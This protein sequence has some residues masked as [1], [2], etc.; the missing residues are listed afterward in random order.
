MRVPAGC[1][2][3]PHELPA[4]V[5][6]I[7][8][9]HGS[10]WVLRQ[11][12][13]DT[14]SRR[15]LVE[16]ED[17][18]GAQ[19][20]LAGGAAGLIARGSEGGGHVGELTTFVLL[21]HLLADPQID[22]PVWAAGGIGRHSAAAAIAGGAAGVVLDAQLALVRE[23]ALPKEIATAIGAMDGSETTLIGSHRVYTRPD[24]AA[25]R[26]HWP[27]LIGGEL[28]EGAVAQRLGADGFD[29]QLLAV[30]QDGAFARGLAEEF[31]TAGALVQG[32]RASIAAHLADAAAVQPLRADSAFART[33]GVRYP[34]AQ[35]P[36]TRVSDRAAFAAHVAEHGG[37]PFLALALMEG[38]DVRRLLAETAKLLG[39][40]PWGVGIL[41]FAPAQVREAQLAAIQQFR[42][43]CALIAGGRPSQAAPLEAAGI[44]TFMHV[45]SPGLL[46]RFLHEGARKFVFEGR[47]CGG[48]VGPRA[49]FALWD[50]QVEALLRFGEST[51]A[52]KSFFSE[53]HVLFAGGIHDERSAAMA[54]A[55]AAP[56]AARGAGVGV[57]MGTAYL[58]T[59]EAVRTQAIVPTF[60]EAAVA[61]RETVLLETSPGHAT[62]C[63][64]TPFADAFEATKARL[65]GDGIPAQTMWAELEQLNLGRLR[66]A[67]K[68][69]RRSGEMLVTVDEDEQRAEGMV[70]IGQVAALR[71]AT[72]TIA[73]L[74]EQVT[75][76]ASAFLDVAARAYRAPAPAR[77]AM[78]LDVAIVG[79]ACIFPKAPDLE[80]YWANILH[81]VDA[82]TDVPSE[83]WDPAVH[84]DPHATGAHA[85]RRTP[86]KWGGFIP[87]IPFDP[88]TYGIPP[89]SLIGIE[90][91]Q[92]LALHVAER[93]L[94]DAGYARRNPHRERTSVVFGAE[95]GSDLAAAYNF[96][97]TFRS[98]FGELPP[99]FDSE[100]PELTEDSFPGGLSNVIAGRIANRLDLRGANFTV[101]AACASSLAALD[102][103]C[104]ELAS[105]NSDMVLCGGAD[106]HNT[107]EDYFLFSSVHALS[108]TGRPRPF[109]A[110]SDGIALGEGVACVVL[111][112]LAD[113]ERDGDRIYAVIRGIG[114]SSD[115]R[116]LGLTAPRPEGQQLALERAYER[117][118]IAPQRVGLVEAHGT[119]TVVGD[120]TELAAI[121]K[122]YSESGVAPQSCAIGSVKSQIGHTKCAAGVAGVIK[123][124]LALWTGVRPPTR[125]L[126]QPNP[127]WQRETNPFFFTTN[128]L[129]WT[130]APED[131][132]AGVSGFG[133]GGT[134]FHAVLSAYDGAPDP[135]QAIDAW[136]AELFVFHGRDRADALGAIDGLQALIAAN[137]GAARPWHL[138]DLARTLAARE[139]ER[140]GNLPAQVALVA[141]DLDDLAVKL[142]AARAFEARDGVFVRDE[143]TA[144]GEVAFLF[145]GQGSQRPGMLADLFVAFPALRA[146]LV[147][148]ARYAGTIFPPTAFTPEEK[149]R[150]QAALTDTRVA[151]PALG[152]AG[153]AVH[154]LLASFG[155]RPAMAGGHSYGELVALCAAGV[156]DRADLL[157][158]SAA[159]AEAIMG[160]AGDDPG[161]MAAV[162][163]TAETTREALGPASGV[164]IANDN[165]P[166]QVVISG[167]TPAIEAAVERLTSRGIS[168]KRIP[169][170]CGFHSPV[171][172]RAATTFGAHLA[173][174]AFGE[175]RLPVWSNT[176]ASRYPANDAERAR[177]LLAEQVAQPVCF[178]EQIESMYAAG[179]R[180]FVETGPGRVLTQ[181]VDKILADRPH[182]AI[183]CEVSGEP[184]LRRLML[185]LAALA[186]NGVPVDVAALFAERRA[187]IVA[188]QDAPR[189]P[190]WLVDGFT[191][192]TADGA[193]L[194]GGLRPMRQRAL[195]AAAA[196]PA[197]SAAPLVAAAT[198]APAADALEAT[199]LEFLRTSR[200]LIASQREVVLGLLGRDPARAVHAPAPVAATNGTAH[201]HAFVAEPIAEPVAPVAAPAAA[202][203]PAAAGR[204]P[205]DVLQA[206]VG[207]VSERTGYP[208]EML[209]RDLDLEADLSIDSIKR[210]EIFAALA[211]RVGLTAPGTSLD[212]RT[213]AELSARKTL[214]AIVA[215]IV[216]RV[217]PATVPAA[218]PA[219][220]AAAPQ[221]P[222]RTPETIL[223]GVVAVVS[224]RTGYP[225]EMLDR[226][227]DL[228]ADLS[229]DSIKRTEIFAALADRL[230]L[231]APGTGLDETALNQLSARK[232]LGAIVAWIIERS[233][234]TPLA[235]TPTAAAVAAAPTPLRSGP[236]LRRLRVAPRAIDSP[237]A[238][239]PPDRL[240]KN[241]IVL[242]AD[243]HGIAS[244]L[245]ALLR[246]R[247]ADVVEIT[248][249]DDPGSAI[250]GLIYLATADR[251]RAPVLPGAFAAVRAALA[252]GANRL[253]VAT[254][255]GGR[256]GFGEPNAD[257]TEELLHADAGWRG[258]VRTVARERPDVLARAVDLDPRREPAEHA[259]RLLQELLD[260]EGPAVTGWQGETRYTLDVEA[261]ELHVA[262][263]A[264]PK[265][266]HLNEQSVVLLT[267]GARG[268]TAQ[269]A[270]TLAHDTGC[271]VVLVG[272]TPP[273][274]VAEA[275]DTAS[276]S[277]RIALRRA[278]VARGL[279]VPAEIDAL[280][281]Q[282]LA[283]RELRATLAHLE[284]F[285]ASV[286][287][288]VAD[289]RDAAAVRAIVDR[290]TSKRGRLDLVVHGAGT[291]ED[292]LIAEKSDESFARVWSTKVDGALALVAALPATTRDVVFFGSIA[293]VFG[294]R[295][296]VDYAAANDALDMLALA[297]N[298][299]AGGTRAIA[300]DWGPWAAAAGGMVSPELEAEYTR[301]G[302]AT[303][304]V[305]DGVRAF[306]NELVHGTR[307]DAQAVYA[308]ADAAT[309]AGDTSG[310]APH[311][312]RA[313][314]V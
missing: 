111:K 5:T 193:Y 16:V 248:V 231:T 213:L 276:A 302:I 259:H 24:L 98:Y 128:A 185:A 58:F 282:I 39:D 314:G 90:P 145:P 96:R 28:S 71:D 211:E 312:L 236:P 261:A 300:L 243:A 17:L 172:A 238:V 91:V 131:R 125:A 155:V 290:V 10:P 9:P 30:G 266:P 46:E 162:T 303:I 156:I 80:Q 65:A 51:S 237:Y 159:R 212:E 136:P 252:A 229:I 251:E 241:R 296:Q 62:R 287:Y 232:T 26:A 130:A 157:A 138:R 180:V 33:R 115:G 143:G 63:A 93:A 216:E 52:P 3:E 142:A 70:M 293:G 109:D 263:G 194:P 101:D 73:A 60:Q 22:V 240:R 178:V 230:E 284:R 4:G 298:R 184:G 34:V 117:A 244:A 32:M 123:T 83:R 11:A 291:L 188:V 219:R 21:Q 43:P 189:R 79:M 275:P 67:A 264:R 144:N 273:P 121:S 41:G 25:R 75:A 177:R 151:Q 146:L 191:I 103:S 55:L 197:A 1:T 114:S 255:N 309:L 23:A 89:S 112:R 204:E 179:A 257:A 68:G 14:P 44:D 40:R 167:P 260:D 214:Q 158:M 201:R 310:G 168:A 205:A 274:T 59:E 222:Q 94:H 199:V 235:V 253:L 7:I 12:Q 295:G 227:L 95:A 209:D 139:A 254:A 256:F 148:G 311:A 36:M 48:H 35:G 234:P 192:R 170:A 154:D 269:I 249:G 42:P 239:T 29:E 278:L 233:S 78:P 97:A 271:H 304:E 305:A 120:R 110:N 47:E 160:A 108:P 220:V 207:I 313:V 129:P 38:E 87:A 268:I 294:N 124:A 134:N 265:I 19:R 141:D 77:A 163:A 288:E 153:L 206:V 190:G 31:T 171:V 100:L 286:S 198:A 50:A 173:A 92:L 297:L 132:V 102:L 281:A 270:S 152:I 72:T 69:V 182:V 82:I 203:T 301:R 105:G 61:C 181:L 2:L 140:P 107:V 64:R 267:G 307:A 56:L 137:D 133:F 113:A 8:L 27:E 13:D 272:R 210:T 308:C 247:G 208:P 119:G 161:A 277:D 149:A 86:S 106:L 176:T 306:V 195:P 292:R 135:A 147:E 66:L 118:G 54:A 169:V 45:P 215:W 53:L 245:A 223:A 196:A 76:G 283:E 88:M 104:K 174:I 122:M 127:V 116:S 175:P 126:T 165:A 226:D 166:L 217:A 99:D 37:L 74:H 6:T 49:S 187:R 221:Q 228:E 183:P 258:L 242:V 289:V 299:R 15:V 250:D 279:R 246:E 20:A 81:G 164:V 224:E 218:V 202:A 186:V 262:D 280:S 285:A 200:E 57:L 150:Q 225:P 85:G 18:E 84:W